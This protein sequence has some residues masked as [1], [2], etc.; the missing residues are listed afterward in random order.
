MI[1]ESS[2]N[3]GHSYV[4]GFQTGS[5]NAEMEKLPAALNQF[6]V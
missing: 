6:K 4:P 1:D 5:R 3:T 2:G